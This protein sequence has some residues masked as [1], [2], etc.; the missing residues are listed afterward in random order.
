MI[1]GDLRKPSVNK[2]FDVKDNRSLNSYLNGANTWQSQVIMLP[3]TKLCLLC[4]KQN[5]I[6]SEMMLSS[7]KMRL[8]LEE[9]KKEFDYIIVDS[10]PAYDLNDPLIINENVDASLLVVKQDEA[11]TRLINET[12]SSLVDV[13]NNLIGC[14]YNARVIDLGKQHRVYGYHYG[15]SRYRKT[16]GRG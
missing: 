1:D 5:L 2:I 4:A 10:S 9:A 16:E 11:T 3:K 12:I 8:L 14:I 13:K 6:E 15:Y 7:E